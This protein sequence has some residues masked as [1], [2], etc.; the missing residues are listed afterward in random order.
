MANLEKLREINEQHFRSLSNKQILEAYMEYRIKNSELKDK[1]E[2]K[3]GLT[4]MY[5]DILKD[6]LKSRK[7]PR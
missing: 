5:I 3:K 7:N 4:R 2:K 1:K 6:E